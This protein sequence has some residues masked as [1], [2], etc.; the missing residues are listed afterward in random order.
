MR[1]T[2]TPS[3]FTLSMT[4]AEAPHA[5]TAASR[6]QR[7]DRTLANRTHDAGS[8]SKG[9]I[10]VVPPSSDFEGFGSFSG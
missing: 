2:I 6:S 9:L 1:N 10:K 5:V 7:P 4:A 3:P 8:A